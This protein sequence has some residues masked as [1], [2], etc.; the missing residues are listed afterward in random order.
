[1]TSAQTDDILHDLGALL[2][3]LEVVGAKFSLFGQQER[4]DRCRVEAEVVRCWI[5]N[6]EAGRP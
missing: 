3:R 6:I 1:M 2:R 4:A 5:A